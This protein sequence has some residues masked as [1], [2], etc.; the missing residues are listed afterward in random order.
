MRWL[1]ANSPNDINA[2]NNVKRP[3]QK[4]G[5]KLEALLADFGVAYDDLSSLAT[6]VKDWKE[7]WDRYNDK[8]KP[9]Q[10]RVQAFSEHIWCWTESYRY[11][12]TGIT[13]GR[14]LID[15]MIWIGRRIA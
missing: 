5:K 2:A 12:Y 13:A 9:D 3:P 1:V 8:S 15:L 14:T 10:I 11:I 7:P 6:T 4:A